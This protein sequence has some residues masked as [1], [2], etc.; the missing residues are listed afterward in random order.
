MGLHRL[1][2]RYRRLGARAT[3]DYVRR[4]LT[5]RAIRVINRIGPAHYRCPC[6][7]W[8][9][10]R[11]FEFAGHG[12]GI[13]NYVCP[14]CGSHPRHRAMFGYLQAAVAKLAPGSA[15][16]HLAPEKA[17]APVFAARKDLIYVSSDLAL[18]WAAVRA[19]ITAMPFRDGTFAMVISSHM[20]EH[21]PDDRPALAELSRLVA[22]GGQVLILVP[23]LPDWESRPTVEF[24]APDRLQDDHWRVYGS[25]LVGRIES[26]GL[27]CTTV[28][29]SQFTTPEQRSSFRLE[30][31]VLF[32]AHKS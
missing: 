8:E 1:M 3:A 29:F 2:R 11:F 31:D 12:Y 14:R 5:N 4:R 28:L 21:L 24:G 10:A 7:G 6:C 13:S 17:L 18:R 19:N 30:Q 20:L 15:I 9:G 22:P 16:L 32:L 23:T 27:R 26:A 25:D